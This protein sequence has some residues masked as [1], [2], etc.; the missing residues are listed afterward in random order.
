MDELIG[1]SFRD[2]ASGKTGRITG[3]MD[4]P[5][6]PLFEVETDQQA[7]IPAREEFIVEVDVEE[8]MVVF[9]LPEGLI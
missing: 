9:D 3:F 5:D 7:M 6:N 4:I 8:K 1:Y 2:K